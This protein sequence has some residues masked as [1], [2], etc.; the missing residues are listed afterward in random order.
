MPTANRAGS[1]A[2]AMRP[3]TTTFQMAPRSIQEFMVRFP[4]AQAAAAGSGSAGTTDPVHSAFTLLWSTLLAR[5]R[6]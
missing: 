4:V 1:P 6:Q 2:P 5:E 3:N